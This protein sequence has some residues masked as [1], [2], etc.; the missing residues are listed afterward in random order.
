MDAIEFLKSATEILKNNKEVDYRNA[1]SRAYYCAYHKAKNLVET[2]FKQDK[3]SSGASHEK[4]IKTLQAEKNKQFKSIGN[5]LND[6]KRFRTDADYKLDETFSIQDAKSVVQR[7][8]KL[9]QEIEQLS[10]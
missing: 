1:T 2:Q 10:Q 7:A 3:I 9:V 4:I 8:S 5:K 6:L